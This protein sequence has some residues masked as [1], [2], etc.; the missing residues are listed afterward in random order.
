MEG[1]DLSCPTAIL[2]TSIEQYPALGCIHGC[3][4]HDHSCLSHTRRL[5]SLQVCLTV[6]Q[7]VCQVDSIMEVD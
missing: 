5:A 2:C 1:Q 6:P 3:N 7:T 4:Q